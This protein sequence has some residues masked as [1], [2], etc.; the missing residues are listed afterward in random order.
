MKKIFFTAGIIMMAV[1]VTFAHSDMNRKDPKESRNEKREARKEHR[2]VRRAE[3]RNEV[4]DF[5]KKQFAIDFVDATNVHYVKTKD[6]E[7]MT[8]MEGKKKLRAYYDNT[9]NLVGT[10]WKKDF[11]DLPENA[12]KEILKKYAGYTINRVIEFNDNESNDADM[13]LYG[14]AFADANNYFAELKNDNKAIVVRVDL[15]GEVSFFANMK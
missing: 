9:S 11:V 7:E 8:F 3:Y 10:T 6:F 5:T 4:S 13:I 2:M 12:Q 15:A 14:T 1:T